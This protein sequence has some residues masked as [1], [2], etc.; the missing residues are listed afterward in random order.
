MEMIK[1]H[2]KSALTELY[3][4][5]Q[6][7]GIFSIYLYGSITGPDFSPLS[8]DIDAIAVV[9]SSFPPDSERAMVKFLTDHYIEIPR[10]GVR[11]LYLEE[12][13]KIV[14]SESVLT[15]FI[16]TAALLLDFPYWEHVAGR[17][18][19]PTDFRSPSYQAGLE[20]MN[21]VL[22]TWGWGNVENVTSDKVGNYLKVIARIIWMLDGLNDREYKFSYS[23]IAV[24]EDEYKELAD[25]ILE[26]K[27]DGWSEK[28]FM[29]NKSL[30][31][32]FVDIFR[33]E[34]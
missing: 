15:S 12:M 18:L 33:Q 30:F 9:D 24:R 7:H 34:N 6:A 25:L 19:L 8:S 26:I 27:R 16:P 32:D 17:E 21:G 13:E 20:A 3:S 28:K 29:S 14:P 5:Y 11:I 1:E 4:E 22:K 2:V 23:G 10:F 31:Q